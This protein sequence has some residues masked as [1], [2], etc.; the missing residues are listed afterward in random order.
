MDDTVAVLL[1]NVLAMIEAHFAV[2]L[3]GAVL[4]SLNTHL[5]VKTFA[6]MLAH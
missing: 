4:N 6:F 1:P 5:D 2:P 3:A